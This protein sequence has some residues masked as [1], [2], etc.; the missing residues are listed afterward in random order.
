[1]IATGYSTGTSG[2]GI[3]KARHIKNAVVNMLLVDAP[4]A[5]PMLLASKLARAKQNPDTAFTS[6]C[7]LDL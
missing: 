5:F 7:M 6:S 4:T 3:T 1:M 2:D